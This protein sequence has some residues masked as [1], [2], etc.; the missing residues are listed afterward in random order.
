MKKQSVMLQGREIPLYVW[1]LGYIEFLWHTLGPGFPVVG[2]F[3]VTFATLVT[4]LTGLQ[5]GRAWKREAS[6][7]LEDLRS[8]KRASWFRA[9]CYIACFT[10]F[11]ALLGL[12]FFSSLRPPFLP[13]EYDLINYQMGVPRQLLIRA[14]LG[15]IDWSVADLWPM[16]MQWGMAPISLAFGTINKLPQFLFSLGAALCMY[17]IAGAMPAQETSR[18][19]QA[20]PALALFS[21]HGVA[22]QLGTGMMDLPALYLLL[23]CLDSLIGKRYVIA[24]LALAVYVASK[25]FHPFQIGAVVAGG[26]IWLAIASNEAHRRPIFTRFLPVFAILSV[27]LLAR[28]ASIS[29]GATGT[30]L[31]PFAA[32]RL[33]QPEL[34]APEKREILEQSASQL[35]A[36]RDNYGLGRGPAAF[37]QH[38]WRVSVPTSGVNNEYDYPLGL[39]WVLLLVLLI[40]S[41]INGQWRNPLVQL[42]LIFWVLWWLNSHQSRWLYPVLAFGL[43]ATIPM[44]LRAQRVLPALIAMSFAFTLLSQ[45]RSLTPTI[46]MSA[47]E[48]R[49]REEAKVKWNPD[50]RLE[51]AELLYV[52]KAAQDHTPGGRLWILR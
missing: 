37:F 39:P 7:L 27:L 42:T 22:I 30:P 44:Q 28:S 18:L 23:L 3:T 4:V 15:W 16:A 34:C 48:I 46:H 38:L 17:R 35:L 24:A 5:R 51:S 8:L 50:G 13:Q 9:S 6:G 19:T 43:L 21:A 1:I 40:F 32:C 31:F 47:G 11:S 52:N 49:E 41:V 12:T 33:S 29:M 25:A 20:L 36:T 45:Y 10:F 14:S 26:L 2:L